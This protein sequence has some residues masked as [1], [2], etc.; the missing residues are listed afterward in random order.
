MINGNIEGLGIS[1]CMDD[2]LLKAIEI[3]KKLSIKS[4]LGKVAVNGDDFYYTVMEVEVNP[5]NEIKFE[6][7]KKYIDIHYLIKGNEKIGVANGRKL[8][9]LVPY[10]EEKDCA[11]CKDGEFMS[12]IAMEEKDFCVIFPYEA[13]KPGG[14]NNEFGKIKKAVFKIKV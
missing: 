14:M 7:H 10:V 8:G 5:V 3:M 1:S 11:I 9:I 6:M 4:P 12:I 13:H 2:Y